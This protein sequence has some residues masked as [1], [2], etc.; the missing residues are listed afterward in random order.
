MKKYY[1]A[2]GSNL[3]LEQMKYRCPNAKKAGAYLLKDWALEFRYYLTIRKEKVQQFLQ[4]YLKLM[5]Q[6]KSHLIDMKAIQ[7]IILKKKQKLN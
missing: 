5:K 6:M 3:N 7:L 4:E 1:L 2:Y